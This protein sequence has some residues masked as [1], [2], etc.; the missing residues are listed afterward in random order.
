MA[1]R[2]LN[3]A[4][5]SKKDEFYTQLGDIAKELKFYKSYFKDKVVFC[6]CDDP[7]ES[8][9]FKYFALNFNALGLKKLIAT[10]YNGS[11]VSGNELLLDFGD[12]VDD[13]K[14]VAYKVE[15][16]EVP[17][18]NGDGA[19]NLTDVQYLMQ[20][21][22]NVISILKGNGDFRSQESIEL[23]KQADIVVTN[24]PFSLFR[25]Y[26]AQLMKY[27][28]KF[29]II[30]NQNAITFKEIFPLIRDNKLWLGLTMNGS[31][32]WFQVPDSYETYH[33]IENGKKYAFVAQVVWFTNLEHNVRNE[34]IDLYKY[35]D[36]I[37]NPQYKN[38][39]AVNVNKATEIPCNFEGVMGVPIT[40]LHKYNPNQFEILECCEPA[41]PLEQYRKC[42]YFKEYKSRQITHNG[43]LCQKTYH[44]LLIRKKQ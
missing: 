19:I 32:R 21:D 4:R 22:K 16:T 35:Y 7:Y 31:N 1:G 34:E 10:C 33:K 17:D 39:N 43:V 23:L 14:K 29:L 40:F 30:G 20:N 38:Y 15:I 5:V 25:E 11:P 8:N 12:T 3:A 42:S 6:N 37:E 28:K 2:D 44:R 41:I 18:V 27:E 26:V 13:P 36:K 9:F 24:P